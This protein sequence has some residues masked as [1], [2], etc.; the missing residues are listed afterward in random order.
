MMLLKQSAL[1]Q[2]IAWSRVCVAIAPYAAFEML[3]SS[4][5]LKVSPTYNVTS[6]GTR[7]ARLRQNTLS[8]LLEEHHLERGDVMSCYRW[9]EL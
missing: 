5:S 8:V 7:L 1:L 3:V 9:H 2:S 4:T 6:I